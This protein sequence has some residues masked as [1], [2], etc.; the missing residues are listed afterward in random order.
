MFEAFM[1][2]FFEQPKNLGLLVVFSTWNLKSFLS[3]NPELTLAKLKIKNMPP[4]TATKCF[5]L[6]CSKYQ[7][8]FVYLT[9]STS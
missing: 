2:S 3:E 4:E 8:K 7:G 6:Y 1:F 5:Q 9:A